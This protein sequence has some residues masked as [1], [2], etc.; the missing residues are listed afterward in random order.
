M[1]KPKYLLVTNILSKLTKQPKGYAAQKITSR[2][3]KQKNAIKSL[4][5]RSKEFINENIRRLLAPG[6]SKF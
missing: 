1:V 4:M 5:L 3:P 2:V 6:T